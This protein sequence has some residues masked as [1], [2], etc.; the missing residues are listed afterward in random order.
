MQQSFQILKRVFVT[1]AHGVSR[2]DNCLAGEAVPRWET[3]SWRCFFIVCEA[4]SGWQP[5]DR[6]QL[7]KTNENNVLT[8]V[9]GLHSQF[10][11]LYRLSQNDR[12]SIYHKCLQIFQ[13]HH[14]LTNS[15]RVWEMYWMTIY[16]TSFCRMHETTES[17]HDV[18]THLSIFSLYRAQSSAFVIRMFVTA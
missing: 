16:E 14:F 6:G 17:W 18:F 1:A 3:I 11:D 10:F 8:D 9:A 2:D 12:V 5:W 4:I 13:V 7:E 15:Q